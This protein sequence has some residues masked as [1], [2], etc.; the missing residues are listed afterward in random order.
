MAKDR[1]IFQWLKELP[2]SET[3]FYPHVL[4]PWQSLPINPPQPPAGSAGGNKPKGFWKW[5]GIGAEKRK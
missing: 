5:V 2:A 1:R 4:E 3:S